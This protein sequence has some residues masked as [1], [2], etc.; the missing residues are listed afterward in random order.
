M[1]D[2]Y[3]DMLITGHH[4]LYADEHFAAVDSRRK[5][6]AI[7]KRV[8]LKREDMAATLNAHL[9]YNLTEKGSIW[10]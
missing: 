7:G 2:E 8:I 9:K 4:R 5:R 3:T 1:D 10:E 6:I